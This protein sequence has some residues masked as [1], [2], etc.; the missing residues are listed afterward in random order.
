MRC[1][2]RARGGSAEVGA[3][4]N[5]F[6]GRGKAEAKALSGLP[7]VGRTSRQRFPVGSDII[8]L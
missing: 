3:L 5:P 8:A 6:F 1:P 7:R 4:S 2:V